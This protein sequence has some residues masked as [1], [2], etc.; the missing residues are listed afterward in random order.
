MAIQTLPALMS[1]VDQIESDARNVAAVLAR[2]AGADDPHRGI[3]HRL[4]V[5]LYDAA[6]AIRHAQTALRR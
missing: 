3:A 2:H 6:N 1:A 5:L 4:G